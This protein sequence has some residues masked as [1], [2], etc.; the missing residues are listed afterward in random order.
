LFGIIDAFNEGLG[1]ENHSGG[2]YWSGHRTNSSFVEAG[3]S[4]QTVTP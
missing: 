4:Q 3:D 2:D 1:F